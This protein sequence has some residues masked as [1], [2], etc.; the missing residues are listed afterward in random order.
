[1]ANEKFK[2]SHIIELSTFYISEMAAMSEL[3]GTL[4]TI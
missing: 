3:N 1:M 4:K 2:K